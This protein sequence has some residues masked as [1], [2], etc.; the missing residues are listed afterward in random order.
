VLK[1]EVATLRGR[2]AFP[3]FYERLEQAKEYHQ[4]FPHLPV[5]HHVRCS[6]VLGGFDSS[7]ISSFHPRFFD[8]INP[9]RFDSTG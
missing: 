4:R 3:N 9:I 6:I 8:H 2:E 7:F 5:K 1:E